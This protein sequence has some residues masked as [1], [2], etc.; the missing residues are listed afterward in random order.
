MQI[1]SRQQAQENFLCT[2]MEMSNLSKILFGMYSNPVHQKSRALGR[3]SILT[4]AQRKVR[5]CLCVFL[6]EC[7]SQFTYTIYAAVVW[8]RACYC[9]SANLIYGILLV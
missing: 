7:Q 1:E 2:H 6:T 4:P 3:L 5:L 8:A 9:V